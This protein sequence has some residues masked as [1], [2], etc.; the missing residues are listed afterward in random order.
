M[1]ELLIWAIAAGAAIGGLILGQLWG[2]IEGKQSGKLEAQREAIKDTTTRMERGR[3]AVRDGRDA[4]DP[5]ER[6][7]NNDARW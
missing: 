3:A 7:W 5:A 1:A 6:L 2:R 4:P